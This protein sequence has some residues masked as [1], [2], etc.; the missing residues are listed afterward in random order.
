MQSIQLLSLVYVIF[1]EQFCHQAYL[2]GVQIPAISPAD[3]VYILGSCNG[4][5]RDIWM[6][7]SAISIVKKYMLHISK[8]VA[9]KL[10]ND[11]VKNR[12]VFIQY[13][14]VS[15]RFMSPH[16]SGKTNQT[17][18][19]VCV[20]YT[21]SCHI[22]MGLYNRHVLH[23][24]KVCCKQNQH[25]LIRHIAYPVQI[26]NQSEPSFVLLETLSISGTFTKG[27]IYA[28]INMLPNEYYEISWGEK[29]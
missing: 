12:N 22:L 27:A 23:S 9:Y 28:Y 24:S 11:N 19:P 18:K 21:C 15:Y 8:Y 5:Q 16:H 4:D 2:N 3:W 1:Y 17:N 20:L 13:N 25:H 10:H 6:A 7:L 29:R 14:A 26:S